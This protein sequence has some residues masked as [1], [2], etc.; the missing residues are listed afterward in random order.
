[1]ASMLNPHLRFR[2]TF[3]ISWMVNAIGGQNA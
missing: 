3:G 1:M 2:G